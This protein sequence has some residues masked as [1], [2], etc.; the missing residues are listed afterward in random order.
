MVDNFLVLAGESN[1]V[2]DFL[3]LAGESN[4][5]DDFLVL[6]G[7][8]DDFLLLAG[9]S[10][11]RTKELSKVSDLLITEPLLFPSKSVDEL[12]EDMVVSPSLA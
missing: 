3:V 12:F 5:V 6:A 2:E 11:L 10:N 8:V 9:E 4:L 1:L 7:V